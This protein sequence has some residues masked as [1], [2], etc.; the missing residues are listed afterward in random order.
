MTVFRFSSVYLDSYSLVLPEQEVTSAEI[1]DSLAP[2]YERLEIPHGTLEK[3]SGV[4]ARRLW[5]R[6]YPP[7]KGATSA[8]MAALE[9]SS[10]TVDQLQA[11]V[12]CSVT[13]DYFEPSTACLVARNIGLPETALATDVCN[14]CIGFSNG[15]L[16]VANLIESGVIKA[17]VVVSGESIGSILE[18]TRSKLLNS[19]DMTRQQLLKLLP[20]FTLGCGAAACVL[21][22]K[23]IAKTSHR[24]VGAS[25]RCGSQFSDL[26]V[27]DKDYCILQEQGLDPIMHTESSKI[28]PAAA[29]LGSRAWADLAPAIGWNSE[30]VNHIFCHGV[31]KQVNKAFYDT[32]GLQVEKEF[33]VYQNLG[34][35]VSAS[36]PAAFFTGVEEKPVKSGETVLCTA[37]GSGLNAIF[38][39]WQW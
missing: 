14:A 17:G 2:L 37:F 10:V 25:V 18:A 19:P 5:D 23:D 7:S 15:I 4:R 26:C 34:N 38:S 8:V 32:M 9:K 35:L 31:G 1:E 16:H 3:L 27:G 21:V 6:K 36:M 39:A 13:R 29:E 22:H 11:L 24:L 33:Y 30:M 12:S 20:S 28:I